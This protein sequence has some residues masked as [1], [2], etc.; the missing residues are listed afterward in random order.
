[1]ADLQELFARLNG[2]ASS[3][4]HQ[5]QQHGYQQPSVSSPLFSPSP[6]GPR[7]HHQSAVMS[8]NMSMA[9]TPVPEQGPVSQQTP[10]QQSTNLLNLLRFNSQSG[11][12]QSRRVSQQSHVSE[13]A[14]PLGRNGSTQDL[15]AS[16]MGRGT[17]AQSAP[18][19]A[20]PMAVPAPAHQQQ[21]PQDLL[22]RLLNHPK[23]AQSSGRSSSRASAAFSPPVASHK[24]ETVVDDLAQ[25]LADAEAE[26][27]PS[28]PA[29]TTPGASSSPMRV[30]G[31]D[32]RDTSSLAPQVYLRQPL[33]PARGCQPPQPHSHSAGLQAP[34]SEG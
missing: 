18:A 29:A 12:A 14:P 26:Q 7:P 25:D 4:N 15:M 16:V 17:P 5:Q 13:A 24:P 27:V 34:R 22:L 1:M 8:P 30:F 21:N 2:G 28:D 33:R 23:P 31:S 9:N 11:A 19:H 20:L 3:G 32:G 10:Q 6:S